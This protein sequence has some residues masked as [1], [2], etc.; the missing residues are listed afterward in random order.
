MQH[1]PARDADP[2]PT[3]DIAQ[4]A[5][6]FEL[7]STPG[8]A[9]QARHT[10]RELLKTWQVTDPDVRYDILLLTSE[11]VTNAVRHGG[12]RV[13]LHASVAQTKFE[14]VVEDGSPVL[15]EPPL[16]AVEDGELAS[17]AESGRGLVIVAAVAAAWGVDELSTGGKRVWA[18][19]AMTPSL[20]EQRI[21]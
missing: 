7:P 3:S 12:E 14:V 5:A 19:V 17:R 10:V 11:L 15:P 4:L 16:H 13:M 2:G 18:Q 1:R 21:P 20:P 8:A 9:H 6:S